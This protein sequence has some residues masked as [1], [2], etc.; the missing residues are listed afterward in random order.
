MNLSQAADA[1]QAYVDTLN[2]NKDVCA[3]C[4]VTKYENFDEYRRYTELTAMI[5]KLRRLSNLD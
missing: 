5:A 4:N 1:I 2:I 3:C